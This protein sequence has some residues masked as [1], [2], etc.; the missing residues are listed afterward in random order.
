[1]R[2]QNDNNSTKAT[3]KEAQE[4]PP[5]TRGG[6]RTDITGPTDGRLPVEREN[7]GLDQVFEIL[8]NQRR[9]YL[10]QYLQEH[11]APVS[12]SD[13]SEQLAAWENGKEVR[14]ITS[15]ERKRLYVGLYQCHLPKMDGMDIVDFNKP[16]GIIE[17]G[18]NIEML[19]PYLDAPRATADTGFSR[20]YVG[21]SILALVGLGVAVV[22]EAMIGVPAI[23]IASAVAVLSFAGTTLFYHRSEQK[24]ENSIDTPDVGK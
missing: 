20:Y 21:L 11:D 23:E 7:L 5:A 17:P 9:R 19:F 1:M 2:T 13:L 22:M 6:V 15:S 10:L 18:K 4:E 3:G 14:A 24:P 8:K 12:L 16:R